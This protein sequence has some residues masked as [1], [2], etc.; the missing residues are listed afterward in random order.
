MQQQEA[1]E[2]ERRLRIAHHEWWRAEVTR[3]REAMPPEEL[4]AI[5]EEVTNKLIEEHHNPLSFS[6]MV[7]AQT[8]ALVAK[9]YNVQDF[10]E[11]K[12]QKTKRA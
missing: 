5:Q 2:Q 12:T 8:D 10:E 9:R 3:L 4:A 11:W 7:R 1:A 6:V